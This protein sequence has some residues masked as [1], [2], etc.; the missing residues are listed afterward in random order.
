MSG[1]PDITFYIMLQYE[2][3][4]RYFKNPKLKINWSSL[5]KND[6]FIYFSTQTITLYARISRIWHQ[7]F[8]NANHKQLK[9][10]KQTYKHHFIYS[11]RKY[12]PFCRQSIVITIS[13]TIVNVNYY[14]III[15]LSLFDVIVVFVW[16]ISSFY[17]M[18]YFSVLL[19]IPH[20]NVY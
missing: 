11:L 10:Q 8:K 5:L 4:Y 17:I 13:C 14:Q 19:H 15:N 18:T 20:E 16:R 12:L 9:Q 2:S 1:E 6:W 3:C 7:S